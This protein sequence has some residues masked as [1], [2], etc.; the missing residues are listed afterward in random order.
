MSQITRCPSCTTL[1]KVVPDQ[2]R[3][4]EG[5][6]RCGHCGHVFDATQHLQSAPPSVAGAVAETTNSTTQSGAS[7]TLAAT[8]SP[9]PAPE[10][11]PPPEDPWE[12]PLPAPPA[13]PSPEEVA[14][15]PQEA[16]DFAA[17]DLDLELDVPV[18]T[19]GHTTPAQ[20]PVATA[21]VVPAASNIDLDWPEAITPPPPAP[22]SAPPA[23][24]PQ[25]PAPIPAAS[26]PTDID[27]P[28][29]ALEVDADR[30]A[31]AE[32]AN[33]AE[34]ESNPS[35]VMPELDLAPVLAPLPTPEDIFA[36][37][38]PTA[39]I[40]ASDERIEPSG[41][42]EWTETQPPAPRS[43]TPMAAAMPS[44]VPSNAAP[45]TPTTEPPQSKR[46]SPPPA[47]PSTELPPPEV[48]PDEPSFVRAA[49]RQALWRKPAVRLGLGLLAIV[50]LLGLLGQILIHDRHRLA[51]S[52]PSWRPM[53]ELL[54]APLDCTVR[55]HR[56]IGAVVVESSSFNRVDGGVYHFAVTLKNRSALMLEMPAVELTLTDANEQAVVRRVFTPQELGASS[57]LA[58]QAEF[59][60]TL[61]VRIATNNT[62]MA[63]YR[64]LAFYP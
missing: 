1:F 5:W 51:A 4:S 11:P 41:P 48:G 12:I 61:L 56:Q 59:S 20:P 14:T 54:C 10:P 38:T 60:S 7:T 44:A 22:V 63:G 24:A 47:S 62:P 19:T 15:A 55:L 26:I 23:P 16:L 2:L 39:P 9:P 45:H 52:Q 25:V 42:L 37:R 21:N 17:P 3:I 13:P 8:R 33:T 64:V 57:T 35:P 18:A 36:V 6:V 28:E 31:E 34:A 30:A 40:A 53:L 50:L 49:R 58:P 29:P 46:T 43:A 27:W 32:L